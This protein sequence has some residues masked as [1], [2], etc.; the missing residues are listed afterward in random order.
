MK[1]NDVFKKL[2]KK[3][4]NFSQVCEQKKLWIYDRQWYLIIYQ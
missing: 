2:R 3:Q 1:Q 4:K